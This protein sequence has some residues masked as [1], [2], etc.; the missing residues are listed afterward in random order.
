M[1]FDAK[2]NSWPDDNFSFSWALPVNLT[3]HSFSVIWFTPWLTSGVA[4]SSVFISVITIASC[5][6]CYVITNSYVHPFQ[7]VSVIDLLI[8][9]SC[10]SVWERSVNSNEL[11][12]TPGFLLMLAGNHLEYKDHC[13]FMLI[14]SW[15]MICESFTRTLGTVSWEWQYIINM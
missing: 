1:G 6:H 9:C 3:W 15:M 14:V 12:E 7:P 5:D 13:F 10:W 8:C 11:A 4:C 2:S